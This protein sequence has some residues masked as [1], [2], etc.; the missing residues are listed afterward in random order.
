MK[1]E[2]AGERHE[3]DQSTSAA[4]SPSSQRPLIVPRADRRRTIG[5]AGAPVLPGWLLDR[6]FPD[7]RWLPRHCRKEP[8]DEISSADHGCGCRSSSPSR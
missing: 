6:R 8:V 5:A 1:H 3:A 7:D 4:S 2:A